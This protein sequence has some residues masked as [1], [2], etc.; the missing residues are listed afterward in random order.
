M[1]KIKTLK[2]ELNK[3]NQANFTVRIPSDWLDMLR[4]IVEE[5]KLANGYFKMADLIREAVFV[6]L[7]KPV[8]QAN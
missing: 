6:S 2:E 5:R 4:E 3:K 7:I 1:V 8:K